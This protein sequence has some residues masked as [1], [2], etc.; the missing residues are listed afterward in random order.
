MIARKGRP[1][2]KFPLTQ[3]RTTIGRRSGND[4]VLDGWSVS[5]A[6]AV[7]IQDGTNVV[8]EDLRSRNGTFVNGARIERGQLKDGC[9]VRIAD[10]TLTL[11]LHRTAMAYEPTLL[12]RSGSPP[13]IAQFEYLKGS[14]SGQVIS[15]SQTLT[16]IGSPHVCQVT[17]IRRVDDYAVRLSSGPL[18]ARL[19]GVVLGETPVRLYTGD[20]LELGVDRL[21]FHIR[22][23]STGL[24]P[25]SW[26]PR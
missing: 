23:S 13:R 4:I 16:T 12:I 6:H 2:A 21:Q 5:A 19:N 10:F 1:L 25:V 8:V 18:E 14:G 7:L 3:Q 20:V 9:E 22:D 15:L 24:L 11:A 26:T 17:C